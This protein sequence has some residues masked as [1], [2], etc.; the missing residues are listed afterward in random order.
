VRTVEGHD[1]AALTEALQQPLEAGKPSMIIARTT[2]GKG[3][4][5]MEDVGKWHHGVPNDDE[6]AKAV[7]ELDAAI[8][9]LKG[10][11]S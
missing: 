1:L 7:A 11:V 5:F 8:A 3:I 10:G 4:S 2:K 9:K 6:Y